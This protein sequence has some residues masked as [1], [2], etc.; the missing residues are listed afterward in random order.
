MLYENT[1]ENLLTTKTKKQISS[2]KKDAPLCQDRSRNDPWPVASTGAENATFESMYLSE[3]YQRHI[4]NESSLVKEY[5][6]P[7]CHFEYMSELARF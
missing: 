4:R 6:D 5:I 3:K 1:D 2:C 7:R